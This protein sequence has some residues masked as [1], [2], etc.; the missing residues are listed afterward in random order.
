M[1]AKAIILAFFA[2]VFA[3]ILSGCSESPIIAIDDSIPQYYEI[4]N[5]SS[6][7]SD[8]IE[9]TIQNEMEL[10]TVAQEKANFNITGIITNLKLSKEQKCLFETKLMKHLSS[11]GEK[12]NTLKEYEIGIVNKVN[13]KRFYIINKLNRNEITYEQAE[14]SLVIINT[15]AVEM[16]ESMKNSSEK[17]M[18]GQRR[19]WVE[20]VSSILNP[21]QQKLWNKFIYEHASIFFGPPM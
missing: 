5:I 12:V 2:S 11:I 19:L 17:E 6:L 1:K 20:S 15:K 16:L 8:I 10:V 7:S 18:Y 21:E 13:E 4:Q 9:A 14:N 3:L